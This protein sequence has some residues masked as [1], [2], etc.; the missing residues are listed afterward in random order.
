MDARLNNMPRVFRAAA[1][2]MVGFAMAC[3]LLIIVGGLASPVVAAPLAIDVSGNI[4]ADTVW[5][6][7][8][9]PIIVTGTVTVVSGTLTI[10]PGVTVKFN[11]GTGLTVQ[12]GGRL[13]ADGTS[14]QP[15]T[16][17]S[18][19]TPTP[20]SCDW[21][22]IR[23][24]SSNN[25]IRYS[26]IEYARWGI[27]AEPFSGGHDISHNSFRRNSLCMPTPVG[28]AIAGSPDNTTI[29]DNDFISNTSA[30]Y[31]TKA[32]YNTISNNVI[33]DTSLAAIVIIR[34]IPAGGTRSTDNLVYSNTIRGS[35]AE[36]VSVDWG[37]GTLSRP[38]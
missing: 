29:A 21:E 38:M 10:S 16:F 35:L 12:T 13:V 9:S 36:G 15:I 37:I 28:A 6:T 8:Q 20:A 14:S 22:T 1:V 2:A 25:I 33:S 31:V 34:S 23:L 5:S 26:V 17:T 30:V 24:F 7:A 4:T 32:S 11:S 3:G 19:I 18:N 27:Y